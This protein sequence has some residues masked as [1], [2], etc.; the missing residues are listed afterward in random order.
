[1]LIHRQKFRLNYPIGQL[2]RFFF[3][4]DPR[5]IPSLLLCLENFD[6]KKLLAIIVYTT[7]MGAY[8]DEKGRLRP[9][10]G[11]PLLAKR[12]RFA[13]VIGKGQSSISIKAVVSTFVFFSPTLILFDI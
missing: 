9:E 3:P 5:Q 2:C 13:G 8:T 11:M 12:Y 6:K 10:K 7:G 1:M 4:L